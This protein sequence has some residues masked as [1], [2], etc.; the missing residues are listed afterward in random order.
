MKLLLK[1]LLAQIML[2]NVSSISLAE[3]ETDS[4]QE[5]PAEE[6]TDY[7]VTIPND[8][9]DNDNVSWTQNNEHLTISGSGI[10][11]SADQ[12]IDLNEINIITINE[13]I[14]G[15]E[16]SVFAHVPS[17]TVYL[18][19]SLKMIG[20]AAFTWSSLMTV[21]IPGN[22]E[23]L[24]DWAFEGCENLRYITLSEGIREIGAHC[25]RECSSLKQ[26]VLPS[27]LRKLG[28]WAFSRDY[29]L[30]RIVFTG[31]APEFGE[32]VFYEVDAKAYYPAGNQ[33]WNSV[34]SN[35]S[36]GG[37]IQ[38]VP[39]SDLS[40]INLDEP[41]AGD[42]VAEDGYLYG[43]I[44]SSESVD[45]PEGII[46][47]YANAFKNCSSIKEVT[48]PSTLKTIGDYAFSRCNNLCEVEFPSALT[49]IGE[50]A[51]YD[52]S[53]LQSVIC[54]GKKLALANE[55]FGNCHQLWKFELNGGKVS[56]DR[57]VT[58]CENLENPQFNDDGKPVFNYTI[59]KINQYSPLYNNSSGLLCFIYVQIIRSGQI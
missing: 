46:G 58:G 37:V 22:V 27:T 50:K 55:A 24:D 10:I 47:V 28:R 6:Q 38:W 18:P 23:L 53:S 13:G 48:F 34:V 36:T 45:I 57:A 19:N 54:H 33:T 39:Y 26:I 3:N 32:E 30:E 5:I 9:E 59:T 1:L 17:K 35:Y 21:S 52:C 15:I 42:F 14:T 40:E 41:P 56:S 29:G 16:E 2:C 49:G 7:E 8:S 12:N 31:D 25:L 20:R 44:G 51:F 43:Y 11:S 4:P